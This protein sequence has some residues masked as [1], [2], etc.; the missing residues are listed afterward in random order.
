MMGGNIVLTSSV[1]QVDVDATLSNSVVYISHCCQNSSGTP[2]GLTKLNALK[3]PSS[4]TGFAV[5][6][7]CARQTSAQT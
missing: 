2:R 3:C 4:F 5:A 1:T 6:Q 7:T